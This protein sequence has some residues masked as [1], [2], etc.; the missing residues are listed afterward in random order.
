MRICVDK[1]NHWNSIWL[2]ARSHMASLYTWGSVTTLHDLG[3]CVGTAAAFRHFPLGSQSFTVTALGSCV[4]S[5]PY[6]NILLQIQFWVW[7]PGTP[8]VESHSIIA[9]EK[10]YVG[11][12]QVEYT[13]IGSPTSVLHTVW[14]AI[15]HG[16]ELNPVKPAKGSVYKGVKEREQ[17]ANWKAPQV[18]PA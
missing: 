15:S 3:G 4:R 18:A 13:K 12:I 14:I 11:G 5:G 17:Q 16:G 9:H 10:C 2:W 6:V 1:K 7:V 8:L